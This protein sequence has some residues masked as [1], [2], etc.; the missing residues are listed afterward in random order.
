MRVAV[1]R[2]A[3]AEKARLAA[4]AKVTS[5]DSAVASVPSMLAKTQTVR[6]SPDTFLGKSTA[7]NLTAVKP[8]VK[9][10]E[11]P[12]KKSGEYQ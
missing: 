10:E 7:I 8:S 2:T 12:E 4:L 3:A 5:L 1:I 6:E 9:P 11:S